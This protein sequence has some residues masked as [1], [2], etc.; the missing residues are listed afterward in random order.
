MPRAVHRPERISLR[1]SAD[2]KR[3]LERAA[4]CAEKTLTDFVVDVALGEAEAITRAHDVITL[5]PQEWARFE[6]MLLH[7]AP[8]NSRLARALAEHDR[9]VRR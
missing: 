9:V 6:D 4:A 3:K 1:V 2:A 5:T 8:P 7:P